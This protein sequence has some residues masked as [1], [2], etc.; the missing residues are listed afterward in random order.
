MISLGCPTESSSPTCQFSVFQAQ[1]SG[2]GHQ[3]LHLTWNTGSGCSCLCNYLIYSGNKTILYLQMLA[4]LCYWN[5]THTLHSYLIITH[6]KGCC[7]RN[8]SKETRI[9]KSI[10]KMRLLAK[11]PLV[12]QSKRML[13][14]FPFS[15]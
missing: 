8:S 7:N 4:K 11:N 5:Y 2:S 10:F 1:R 3:D 6:K 15:I 9:Y 13:T 14:H 12:S